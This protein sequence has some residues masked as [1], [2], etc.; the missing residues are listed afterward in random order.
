MLAKICGRRMPRFPMPWVIALL[1]AYV[2]H[3]VM[4]VILR[5]E[6]SIPLDG[7][8][9]ARHKM[10]VTSGKACRELGYSPR[11]A[12]EA[13]RE[14]VDYF[15]HRWTPHSAQDGVSKLRAGTPA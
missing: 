1:A 12:E 11:P 8:R 6:P 5:R 4:G 14:A 15:R 10:Y 9:M 7:V 2:D 13:L 3:F